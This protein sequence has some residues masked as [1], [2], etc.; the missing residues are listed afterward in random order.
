MSAEQKKDEEKKPTLAP[1]I[2]KGAPPPE[3]QP[4]PPAPN[5]NE[6]KPEGRPKPKK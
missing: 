1:V 5:P 4:M 3:F 6:N 2:R